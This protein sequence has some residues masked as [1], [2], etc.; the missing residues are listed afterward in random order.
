MQRGKY[1]AKFS[2]ANEKPTTRRDLRSIRAV[3]HCYAN[4]YDR[5]LNYE[6]NMAI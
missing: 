4:N 2:G 5:K 1:N 6:K 3:T